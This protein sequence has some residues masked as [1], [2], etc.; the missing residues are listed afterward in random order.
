LDE[1]HKEAIAFEPQSTVA[2]LL[3]RGMLRWWERYDG[4]FGRLI[5]QVHDSVLL[6]VPTAKV[7][8]VAHL[9][10]KCLEEEIVVNNIKLTIPAD[11]SYST[12]SWADMEEI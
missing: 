11:V 5:A 4:K 12:E 9:L 10:K 3:N 2:D 1:V 7:R 6:E 8:G